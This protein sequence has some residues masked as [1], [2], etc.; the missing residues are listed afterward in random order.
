M[1]STVHCTDYYGGSTGGRRA[2]RGTGGSGLTTLLKALADLTTLATFFH[3]PLPVLGAPADCDAP[4]A[5]CC[6]AGACA[7]CGSGAGAGA[8]SPGAGRWG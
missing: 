8:A 7:G 2:G 5:A 1:L 6:A 3:W 4:G